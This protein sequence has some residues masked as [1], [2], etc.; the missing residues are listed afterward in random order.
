[1]LE[2]NSFTVFVNTKC[3]KI[4]EDFNM[5]KLKALSIILKKNDHYFS[6][7][8]NFKVTTIMVR[9][10]F[11]IINVISAEK[12]IFKKISCFPFRCL[13]LCWNSNSLPAP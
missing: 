8:L 2:E 5:T 10:Y 12:K 11:I 3:N 9:S 4:Y 1:M 13:I 7:V 6:N